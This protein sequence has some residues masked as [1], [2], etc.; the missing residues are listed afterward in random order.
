M[1]PRSLIAAT[2]LLTTGAWGSPEQA[3]KIQNDWQKAIMAWSDKAT[4]A[5]SAEESAAVMTSQPRAED[6]ARNMWNAI[7]GS[8]NQEWTL[9]PASWF[10]LITQ[11]IRA[12]PGIDPPRGKEGIVQPPFAKEVTAV[13]EALLAHHINSKHVVPMCMALARLGDPAS[14]SILEKINEN[15]PD[16]KIQGVAAMAAAV[17]LKTLGDNP[18]LMRK[19]LTYLRKAI[20]ES[21]DVAIGQTTIANLAENELYQIRYLSKGRVAPDLA[22]SD[23][24]GKPIQLSD[25][26][27]KVVVLVFWSSTMPQI[28]HTLEFTSEMVRKFADKPIVVLGVNHD[29][30]P[31]LRS[32]IADES[33]TWRNFSDPEQKLAQVYRVGILPMTY[34]LDRQRKIQYAGNL[35][36][37]TELTADALA[38]D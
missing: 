15:N 12:E 27:G 2:A 24:A 5:V 31:K 22:G 8:L 16:P 10:L 33:V 17:V 37:F 20:I 30:L 35:G 36:T 6:Y 19:R 3:A 25:F 32:M 38:A 14:L 18:D 4:Q 13:K 29:P 28:G 1:H 21:A 34:V 9:E 11:G 23:S 7:G 26:D